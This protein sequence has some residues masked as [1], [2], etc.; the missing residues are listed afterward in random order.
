MNKSTGKLSG[1]AVTAL[2]AAVLLVAI[3]RYARIVLVVIAALLV[4]AVVAKSTLLSSRRVTRMRW[5]IRFRLRPGPGFA[6]FWEVA[7]RWSRLAALHHGRRARPGMNLSRRVVSRTTQYAIRLG[8]A[9]YGRRVYVRAEDQTII[10]AP[11]RSGKT[12]HL[13]DRVLDHPGPAL[14]TESRPDIYY[15]TAGSRA[16]LGPILVFNPEGVSGIP[17]TFR[18]HDRRM[19]GPGRGAPPGHRPCWCGREHR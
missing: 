16:R 2:V 6:T 1:A 7:F 12:G 4:V 9:Q 17:S 3:I 5:R 10:L 18:W 19:R 15:A 14:V 11:P 13:A 8:R